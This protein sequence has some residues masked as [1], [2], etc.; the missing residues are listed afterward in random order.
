MAPSLIYETLDP[1]I[2]AINSADHEQFA[3]RISGNNTECLLRTGE[4]VIMLDEPAKEQ[5]KIE[6]QFRPCLRS[7]PTMTESEFTATDTETVL[8]A[9]ER[10]REGERMPLPPLEGHFQCCHTEAVKVGSGANRRQVKVRCKNMAA[11]NELRCPIHAGMGSLNQKEIQHLLL[12][13]EEKRAERTYWLMNDISITLTAPTESSKNRHPMSMAPPDIQH[14]RDYEIA[15][16]L[17]TKMQR[18]HEK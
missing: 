3:L 16:A 8:Q 9:L 12:S 11:L 10:T 1:I 17:V 4:A 2:F 18:T 15:K 7:M 6:A 5:L 14:H 13:E